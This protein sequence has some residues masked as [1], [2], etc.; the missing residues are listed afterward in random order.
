MF[1][2]LSEGEPCIRL[3]SEESRIFSI[4]DS[5][6][7]YSV[8]KARLALAFAS[9]LS[10]CFLGVA[11]LREDLLSVDCA[12]APFAPASSAKATHRPRNRALMLLPLSTQFQQDHF[13]FSMNSFKCFAHASAAL[14]SWLVFALLPTE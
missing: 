1:E 4:A 12:G 6:R 8:T 5:S 3:C 14:W 7:T 10:T 11:M 13:G 2:N 9:R